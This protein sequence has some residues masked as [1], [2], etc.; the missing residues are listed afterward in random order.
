MFRDV[1]DSVGAFRFEMLGTATDVGRSVSTNPT[2]LARAGADGGAVDATSASRD[3]RDA[4]GAE[5]LGTVAGGAVV[6][7]VS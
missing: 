1:T 6:G 4:A 5:T 3:G 2:E 7:S